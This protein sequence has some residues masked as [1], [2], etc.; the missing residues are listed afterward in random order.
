MWNI[1][2]CVMEEM[3]TLITHWNEQQKALKIE[4]SLHGSAQGVP[5]DILFDMRKTYMSLAIALAARFEPE[6]RVDCGGVGNLS[7]P[8]TKLAQDIKHL[9][10][11]AYPTVPL[12]VREQLAIYYFID[13]LND[14]ELEWSVFQPKSQTVVDV[15]QIG[16]ECEAFR[17]GRHGR[18]KHKHGVRMQR[19]VL[20]EEDSMSVEKEEKPDANSDI[21][22]KKF[23]TK[24]ATGESKRN[25]KQKEQLENQSK[26][27]GNSN[28]N[29][30]NKNKQCAYCGKLGH[31]ENKCFKY[32]D[33]KAISMSET[34]FLAEETDPASPYVRYKWP[35]NEVYHSQEDGSYIKVTIY[36]IG[37]SVI[38]YVLL[39]YGQIRMA[40][41]GIVTPLRSAEFC[42]KI[43]AM[44][45]THQ[46]II[47][48]IAPPLELGHDAVIDTTVN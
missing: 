33:D 27:N 35:M 38:H 20:N 5:S 6:N 12:Q 11:L 26:N 43:D 41:G 4:T 22:K 17:K 14:S 29:K 24:R 34:R 2:N 25:L 28:K 39:C 44:S 32:L 48:D 3:L 18:L 36:N 21:L 8:L 9:V 15:L 7:I 23:K 42:I 47:V 31:W 37:I 16:H 40:D 1:S 13:S 10:Q 45:L 30:Q 46:F 19:E